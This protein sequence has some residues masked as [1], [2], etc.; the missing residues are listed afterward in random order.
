MNVIAKNN[1]KKPSQH[2][3][4]PVGVTIARNLQYLLK[5]HDLT[6]AELA[7]RI[8]CSKATLNRIF[9]GVSSDPKISIVRKLADYFEVPT[10]FLFS[11]NLSFGYEGYRPLPLLEWEELSELNNFTGLVSNKTSRSWQPINLEVSK[12]AFLLKATKSMSPRYP[13]GTVFVV[14]PDVQP[15]DGDIIII[16]FRKN[17][18]YTARE[19]II[20]APRW[21]LQ[22]IVGESKPVAYQSTEHKIVGVVVEK[23]LFQNR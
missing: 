18:I 13:E 6:E 17:D 4:E 19:L 15:I 7:R 22:N 14:D 16:H 8:D 9:R 20:D 12:N 23:R 5:N 1:R 11:E 21:Q 10:S 2:E 3:N